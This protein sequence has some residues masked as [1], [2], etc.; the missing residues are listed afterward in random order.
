MFKRLD[1]GEYNLQPFLPLAI[2]VARQAPDLEIWEAVLDL[3]SS[4]SRVTPP[5]SVVPSFGAIPRKFTSASQTGSEQTKDLVE[6]HLRQELKNCCFVEV[7]GFFEKYFEGR[8]WSPI[9]ESIITAVGSDLGFPSVPT[10]SAVWTWIDNFQKYYLNLNTVRGVYYTTKNKKELTGTKAE[11]QLDLFMKSREAPSTGQHDWANVRVIGE[12]QESTNK[13]GMKFLQ[14]VRYARDVFVTQPTRLF[15]HG[16]LLLG[17]SMELQV[18]DR[19]GVYSATE[20]NVVKEPAQFIK[21]L[22]GYAMMTDEEL[23]MDTFIT[24]QGK[25]KLITLMDDNH[26]EKQWEIELRPIAMQPAIV[27]RATCCYRTIDRKSVVKFS[28]QCNKYVL[29]VEHLRAAHGIKG[30]A[31]LVASEQ[32]TSINE[33]RQGLEF[34][35]KR[36]LQSFEDQNS[37][38]FPQPQAAS[39]SGVENSQARKENP[40]VSVDESPKKKSRPN[41]K[42]SRMNQQYHPSQDSAISIDDSSSHLVE[43]GVEPFRDRTLT[44]LV[45]SPAGRPLA[46]YRNVP[47]FLLALRDAI[48]AH[49]GLFEA[50]ILHRDI[51]PNNIIITDPE[52]ADGFSGILI[53]MDMATQIGPDGRNKGSSA[54]QMTGTLEFMAIEVLRSLD[55]NLDHTYRHDLESFFYVFL[56]FCANYGWPSHWQPR[57]NPFHNWYELPHEQIAIS[58]RGQMEQGGFEDSV[59]PKFSPAFECVKELARNLRDILFSKGVLYT[60]TPLNH[61]SLYK[62]MID[63]FDT[64]IN[65]LRSA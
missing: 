36:R 30:V 7:K 23:G 45:I 33:L 60:G 53:D 61:S 55:R 21:V 27:C 49:K 51:S 2:L 28:W 9:S 46:S 12:H 1:S 40:S 42:S 5:S 37:R 20:F 22:T 24:R 35:K 8:S 6:P 50:K 17:T 34:R 31:Q 10:E 63:A 14:L 64:A 62:S 29:E 18:F 4:L 41:S 13:R 38:N 56:S 57:R 47:E 32:I 39:K 65:H 48:K 59:I 43:P 3:I 11:R 52:E 54:P 25:R 16:F 19:S 15:V 44:C 58:K 26:Q